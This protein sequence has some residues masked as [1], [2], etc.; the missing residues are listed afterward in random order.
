M[1]KKAVTYRLDEDLLKAMKAMAA[2][3]RWSATTLIEYSVESVLKTAGYLDEKGKL[4]DKV[5]EDSA[6]A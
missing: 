1:P 4:T 3:R 6:D 5:S 2:D